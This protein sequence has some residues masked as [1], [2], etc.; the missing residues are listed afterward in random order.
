MTEPRQDEVRSAIRKRY[1]AVAQAP[2]PVFPYPTGREGLLKLG[3]DEAFV[4]LLPLPVAE[5]FCGVANP[6]RAGEIRPG[7]VVLDIGCGAGIDVIR[8]A[9]DTGPA[10]M[11]YGVDLTA[12]MVER[13]SRNIREMGIGNSAVMEAPAELL[14]FEDESIDVV[15]TNGVLNLSLYKRECFGEIHR[16]LRP[17]GRLHLADV[18]LEGEWEE[19]VSCDIE[20]WAT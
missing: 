18:I 3:Y 13:A 17:G 20:S 10:G 19:D 16:V 14:P 8:A 1:E 4:A 6:F 7:E 12:E 5:S 2:K 15:T 9:R 11:V